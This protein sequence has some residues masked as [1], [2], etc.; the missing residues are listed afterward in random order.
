MSDHTERRLAAIVSADVVGYSRLMGRD[1]AGTLAALRDHRTQLFDPAIAEHGGRIVKTMGDG[2]LLEFTSVIDA[3]RCAI[4]VQEGMTVRNGSVPAENRIVFRIGINLGDIIIEGDDIFGDGVNVTARLQEAAEPGGVAIAHAVYDSVAP[5]L[6]AVFI[7]NGEREL[8]NIAN[9]V[10]VWSWPRQLSVA[11]A[12]GKPRVFVAEFE[13][14]SD[15]ER[16]CADDLANELRAHLDRLT[17]LETT[18]D[19][20]AAHFVA[21]GSVRLASGRSRVHARLTAIDRARQIWSDRY[22]ADTDHP[23]ELLDRCVPH[24]AMG[25]RRG[26]ATDDAARLADRDPDDLSLEEA[27]AVAGVSFFTPTMAGWHGGGEIAERALERAPQDF[28]A[29]AMAAAGLGLAEY[30]YGYRRPD[31]AVTD[32]AMRR[33]EH[34]LRQNSR[35]DMLHM[36]HSLLLLYVRRRY[37][38]ATAAALRALEL[39]PDYNMG[40]WALGTVQVFVGDF[41]AASESGQRAVEIERRDPYVH[42]Y[43]RITAY[44]HLGA[45]RYDE[46]ADWFQK[47]DHLTP[48]VA[49]N[50][51]G[52]AVSR[53]RGADEDGARDAVARLLEEEPALSLGAMYPLPY[54][55]ADLWQRFVNDL[56]RAGVPG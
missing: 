14:R 50:L 54:R 49:P 35:S 19:R 6:K 5:D 17:G 42:L 21:E 44:G 56:R 38:D 3:T 2:L 12:E 10:R 52:L 9:P 11:R 41:D 55:D 28:M 20:E 23:F 7:D 18:A 40:H 8:K 16:N 39:N 15:E 13:G 32:L 22:D 53:W 51:V 1:D 47:A 37:R 25:V 4:A 36:T 24:I 46:A 45:G 43:S 27:L 31:D 30:Q 33:I 29:L 48:G 26:V 34:A